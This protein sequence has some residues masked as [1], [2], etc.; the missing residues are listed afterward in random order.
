VEEDHLHQGS[1]VI[2]VLLE[3]LGLL[4]GQLQDGLSSDP[5]DS[6]VDLLLHEDVVHSL[7]EGTKVLPQELVLGLDD[8]RE[9]LKALLTVA[10]VSHQDVIG[11]L[12]H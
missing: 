12:D 8:L 7:E 3:D 11:T 2:V 9:H 5:L 4:L 10:L 1:D 6:V